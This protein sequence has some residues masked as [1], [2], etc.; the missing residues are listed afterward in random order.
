M[1]INADIQHQ[2]VSPE[3]ELF[4]LTD[5]DKDQPNEVFRFCGL[6]TVSW[7]GQEY[8]GMP[9][10]GSGF[11]V[12]SQSF[13]RPKLTIG[14]FPIPGTGLLLTA[15]SAQYNDFIG[16]TITRHRTLE[17]YLDGLPTANPLE[18]FDTSVWK[19]EQKLNDDEEA[20]QW[21][22]SFLGL[23]NVQLPRRRF[24]SNYCNAEY[25][26]DRCG[27][28][29]GAVATIANVPTTNLALDRCGKNRASCALRFGNDEQRFGGFPGARFN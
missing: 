6:G 15:I 24:F 18:Q 4:E 10:E 12:S 7:Q 1:A 9:C 17:K 16:A 19:I 22:L 5:F 28:M 2:S 23:E 13:P 27:Y 3:V 26:G 20:L 11:E 14:N 29:G 8:T 21:E 25:R